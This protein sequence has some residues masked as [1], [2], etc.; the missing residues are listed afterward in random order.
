MGKRDL[1]FNEKNIMYGNLNRFRNIL[2]HLSPYPVKHSGLTKNN[3]NVNS[4][5]PLDVKT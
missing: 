4:N 5:S 1:N 3:K 2:S